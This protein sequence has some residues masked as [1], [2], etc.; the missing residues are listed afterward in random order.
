MPDRPARCDGLRRGDNRIGVD[1]VVPVELGQRAGLAE[2]LHT[3]RTRAMAVD[4]AQPGERCWM[5]VD[6]RDEPAMRRD[7]RQQPLDMRA[8]MDEPAF[9]R[10]LCCGP[11]SIEPVR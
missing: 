2:M 5:T 9:S 3:E 1:A 8:R 4:G 6:Y 7:V 10:P 11:G